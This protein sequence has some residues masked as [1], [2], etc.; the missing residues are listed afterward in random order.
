MNSKIYYLWLELWSK[1][2]NYGWVD[3]PAIMDD[4]EAFSIEE[5]GVKQTETFIWTDDEEA[6]SLPELEKKLFG[7]GK[8]Y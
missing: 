5:V 6:S 2:K 4:E 7:E 8:L 1:V 3:L